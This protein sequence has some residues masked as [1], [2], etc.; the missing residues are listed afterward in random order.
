MYISLIMFDKPAL[1]VYAL[2]NINKD[3]CT[4]VTREI[5]NIVNN[6]IN[7]A[8][9]EVTDGYYTIPSRLLNKISNI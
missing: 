8:Y 4:I 1:K 3:D 5:N 2:Y 9:L 7:N 6:E